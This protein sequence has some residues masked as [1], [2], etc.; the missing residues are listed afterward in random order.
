M[1]AHEGQVERR[2]PTERLAGNNELIFDL[3]H[4]VKDLI[5][6]ITERDRPRMDALIAAI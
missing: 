5:D 3:E 2:C 4:A 1:R 6:A